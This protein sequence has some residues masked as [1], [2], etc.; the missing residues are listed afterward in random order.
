MTNDNDNDDNDDDR[1]D[2][3]E[4]TGPERV[5][6][7]DNR[8]VETK[9]LDQLAHELRQVEGVYHATSDSAGAAN[10]L[11]VTL[12]ADWDGEE[13]IEGYDI[14]DE[15]LGKTTRNR[16]TLV[17]IDAKHVSSKDQFCPTLTF[18]PVEWVAALDHEEE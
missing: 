10:W 7:K 15:V 12:D 17:G 2:P 1:N 4:N 13:T 6:I 5:P 3:T 9:S 11:S 18:R 8:T 16:W 14:P